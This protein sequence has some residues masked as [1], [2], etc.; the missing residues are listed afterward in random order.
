MMGE[1]PL[2]QW[3]GNLTE[4]RSKESALIPP[5]NN[6]PGP[7]IVHC[8]GHQQDRGGLC[9]R[10]REGLCH[11]GEGLEGVGTLGRTRVSKALSAIERSSDFILNWRG[12]PQRLEG[13]KQH[14]CFQRS[15]WLGVWI[16]GVPWWEKKPAASTRQR[17]RPPQCPLLP[18]P[19]GRGRQYKHTL[20]SLFCTKI[21]LQCSH[22]VPLSNSTN[23]LDF[24]F[25]HYFDKWQ[26]CIFLLLFLLFC[27][28]ATSRHEYWGRINRNQN[29]FI[30]AHP[31][32]RNP[33]GGLREAFAE[34]L[35]PL[36]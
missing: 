9:L 21:Y 28:W 22:S 7:G 8:K 24:F 15:L 35:E 14:E 25:Q 10:N 2:S 29:V 27:F 16:V 26:K 31:I 19:C 6:I 13:R 12:S 4:G 34:L 32:R 23:W 11:W 33:P 1:V 20:F 30:E 5:R 18:C 17:E 36:K 3:N